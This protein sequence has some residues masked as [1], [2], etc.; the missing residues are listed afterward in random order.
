MGA[1]PPIS[2]APHLLVVVPPNSPFHIEG[3]SGAHAPLESVDAR[4][5]LG[6]CRAASSP[7]CRVV[8]GSG[9]D[10]IIL[11]CGFFRATYGSST[12]LFGALRSPI[13]EQFDHT[14]RLD[15]TLR[16]AMAELVA[17]EIGSAAMS[18]ALL[19]QVIVTL[20]RRSLS[21][22]SRW[23]ERFAMLRDPQVARAFSTMAADP[24]GPHTVD[25]LARSAGMSRSAFMARFTEVT[26]HSPMR[27]LRGLR[28]RQAA[29]Q[30]RTTNL[31]I[32]EVVRGAGYESRSSFV[33]AFRQTYGRDPSDY[34]SGA[35]P[36][37]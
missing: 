21:S 37:A 24:G 35:R 27:I 32:E 3:T 20:V 7:F 25:R 22:M 8:A 6:E 5:R 34:R 17:Q 16:S 13:V 18:A 31:S 15:A 14:D 11:I 36:S 9:K 2:L 33:R 12:D 4:P 28:M 10:R 30:L 26:G 29:E 19:K 1:E 23:A